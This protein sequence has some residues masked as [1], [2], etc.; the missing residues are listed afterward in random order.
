MCLLLLTFPIAYRWML[1]TL[2]RDFF[3]FFHSRC[4]FK[5]SQN[6]L[7]AWCM[8][9][10][11]FFHCVPRVACVWIDLSKQFKIYVAGSEKYIFSCWNDLVS[12][13]YVLLCFQWHIIEYWW[14]QFIHEWCIWSIL[15]HSFTFSDC[16]RPPGIRGTINAAEGWWLWVVLEL[17]KRSA[18]SLSHVYARIFVLKN[19]IVNSG[20]ICFDGAVYR[21]TNDYDSAQSR[22]W[23]P[24]TSFNSPCC[25][26][27]GACQD[28]NLSLHFR[29]AELTM[30][31][32]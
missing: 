23:E 29:S 11:V 24:S 14:I 13:I 4:T 17:D 19:I 6:I 32:R 15:F 21:D 25:D 9:V 18:T 10:Q 28:T 31:Q 2:S 20:H 8:N 22:C 1:N 7:F 12:P 26:A 27:I 5:N 3:P 30:W 16:S